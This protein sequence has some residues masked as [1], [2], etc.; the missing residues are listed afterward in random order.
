MVNTNLKNH[1]ALK[2]NSVRLIITLL[3]LTPLFIILINS[4]WSNVNLMSGLL[5]AIMI[6]SIVIGLWLTSMHLIKVVRK[7]SDTDYKER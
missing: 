5:I 2:T 7:G 1:K 3:L 6:L 4:S